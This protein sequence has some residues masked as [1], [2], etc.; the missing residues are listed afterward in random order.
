MFSE[1][2]R[3]DFARRRGPAQH[4]LWGPHSVIGAMRATQPS[5]AGVSR[6]A[7]Q[8][9]SQR[10]R[11]RSLRRSGDRAQLASQLLPTQSTPTAFARPVVADGTHRPSEICLLDQN[12]FGPTFYRRE[13]TW[14]L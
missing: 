14:G 9:G 5:L 6:S 1:P 4:H 2:Q 8:T 7:R 10:I 12:T 3:S 13:E 11:R